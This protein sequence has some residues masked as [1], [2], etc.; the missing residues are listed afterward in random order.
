VKKFALILALIVSPSWAGYNATITSSAY[1]SCLA[2]RVSNG[3]YLTVGMAINSA[4]N[5]AIV[6]KAIDSNA[7]T[8]QAFA[9]GNQSQVFSGTYSTCSAVASGFTQPQMTNGATDPALVE[10]G[11][12]VGGGSVM[13]LIT[14]PADAELIAGAFLLLLA[15]AFGYRQVRRSIE[16]ADYSDEKH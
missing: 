7:H 14:N 1:S 4:C 6:V 16:T 15:I 12:S 8:F 11:I 13:D 2:G 3:C 5:Y 9:Q 10:G